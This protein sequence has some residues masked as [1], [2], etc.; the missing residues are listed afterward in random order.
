M[1]TM[2][3]KRNLC[4]LIISLLLNYSAFANNDDFFQ[5]SN[6]F[7]KEAEFCSTASV[8]DVYSIGKDIRVTLDID[9]R[10][11]KSL[12]VAIDD[13]KQRWF[14]LHCP[15]SAIPIWRQSS[16]NLVIK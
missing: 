3:N 5:W 2:N 12:S 13:I 14:A 10:W 11:A 6:L 4:V 9:D 1:I 16:I 15:F 7:Y 8:A